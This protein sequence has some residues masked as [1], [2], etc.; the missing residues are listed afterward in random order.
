MC[1]MFLAVLLCAASPATYALQASTAQRYQDVN[2]NRRKKHV[3][4]GSGG[5][6]LA[7]AAAAVGGSLIIWRRKRLPVA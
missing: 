7:L 5:V 3:P 2:K 4:E 1:T 6:I